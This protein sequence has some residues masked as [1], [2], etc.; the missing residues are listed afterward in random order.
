LGIAVANQ[1]L[2]L[3]TNSVEENAELLRGEIQVVAIAQVV[4]AV[5]AAIG[6]IYL[7]K[8]V[9]VT[10]LCSVLLAFVLDP[11]VTILARVHIPRSVGAAI[12]LLLLMVVIGGFVFFFYSRALN[13]VDE[14][15]KYSSTIRNSLRKVEAQ[16]EKIETSTRT[17]IPDDKARKAV[18]VQL[19]EA[20]GLTRMITAGA[21][22]GEA[23][24][25]ASFVPF[26]I[27]FMLTWK[28]HAHAATLHIFPKHHR[29][30]AYRT[31]GRISE[32]VRAFIVSN[33]IVGVINALATTLVFWWAGLP[34]FYFLGP[35]SAF[36]GLI[37][38]LG[39]F[40]ALLPPVAAGLG[41]LSPGKLLEVFALVV[42]LHLISMNVVYPKV[43]GKR[44][45]LN[46]LAVAL[47][48]LFWAWIWGALGLI[49]AVPLVAS[50]KIVCDY[51]EPLQG[52]A[53]W[54]GD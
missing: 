12:A 26:L 47:A 31:I 21:Q 1:E 51:V 49:L 23:A 24:L 33:F 20:P 46:P 35:I 27:Y 45:R 18:P 32:M 19:Q 10:V 9:M 22:F 8:I 11:L 13:F 16:A 15:P 17:M 37:P 30:T 7:L 52:L 4:V 42:G 28:E 54:L 3:P 2:H 48:L 40:F 14:L 36:A 43:I 44:L 34:Y 6:L 41:I 29:L 38:N 39:V 5:A 25:A 50:A 53:D